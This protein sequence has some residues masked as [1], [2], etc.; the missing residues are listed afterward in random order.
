MP[1]NQRGSVG[2]VVCILLGYVSCA[3]ASD[4][5]GRV[6][7]KKMLRRKETREV[8]HRGV[9]IILWVWTQSVWVFH[10]HAQA[11]SAPTPE[12]VL[13]NQVDNAMPCGD[14]PCPQSS[15]GLHDELL[16]RVAMVTDGGEAWAHQRG[17]PLKV[18]WPPPLL[19]DTGPEPLTGEL[20]ARS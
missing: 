17:L 16:H 5:G 10:V 19:T 13:N 15:R 14:R 9:Q 8:W 1:V 18:F 6:P 12:D 4:L 7:E 20:L 3:L 2:E 11:C